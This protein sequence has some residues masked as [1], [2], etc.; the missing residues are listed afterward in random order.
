M[1]IRDR[2]FISHNLA[3]VR[4]ISHRIMVLYL[5]RVM[6]LADR[7]S[8]YSEPLH[9]Y[10]KALIAAVPIPDP[11][12]ERAKRRIVLEGD[13]PSPLAPPSG[14]V[15]RTRCPRATGLCAERSPSLEPALAGHEVACHHWRH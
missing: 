15:F 3:V 1:C 11:Q 13:L 10:T 6:E 2:I 14:C 5:G 9:P 8:L 12:L 4:H 7:D